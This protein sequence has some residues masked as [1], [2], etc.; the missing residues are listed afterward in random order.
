M[1]KNLPLA[2]IALVITT[3]SAERLLCAGRA[4]ILGGATGP[5]PAL[6]GGAGAS[7]ALSSL[8][9]HRDNWGVVD[10]CDCGELFWLSNTLTF[11]FGF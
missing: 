3:N 5:T 6:S 11:C 8:E 7:R 9:A 2:G 1:H 4:P 10:A